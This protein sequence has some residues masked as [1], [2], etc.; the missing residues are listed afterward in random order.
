MKLIINTQKF[1]Y[2][3]KTDDYLH[4]LLIKPLHFNIS[5]SNRNYMRTL[6]QIT[7]IIIKRIITH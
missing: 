5:K 3:C 6:I 7:K 4:T 1:I 2:T